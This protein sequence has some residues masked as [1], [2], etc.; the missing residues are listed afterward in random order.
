MKQISKIKYVILIIA[1]FA[2]FSCMFTIGVQGKA[3]KLFFEGTAIEF[4]FQVLETWMEEDVYHM[5]YY[6]KSTISGLMDGIEFI[7][8]NEAYGHLKIEPSGDY[9]GHGTVT[10]YIT[11]NGFVGTYYGPFNIKGFMPVIPSRGDFTGKYIGHGDG[12]FDGWKQFGTSWDLDEGGYG[13][14]G[15]TL[16]PN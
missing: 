12:D 5:K 14:S 13:F 6:R 11:W 16:I 15:T 3:I 10:A 4:D 7:G 2:G 8:Y 9:T 1:I